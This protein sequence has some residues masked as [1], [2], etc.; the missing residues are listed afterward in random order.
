MDSIFPR[1]L[2][3]GLPSHVLFHNLIDLTSVHP[4]LFCKVQGTAVKSGIEDGKRREGTE[5]RKPPAQPGPPQSILGGPRA[6]E[7]LGH[8]LRMLQQ[9]RGLF[10]LL[11]ELLYPH[12]NTYCQ[13]DHKA[14]VAS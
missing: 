12:A 13:M 4:W 8:V 14:D 10:S 11:Q 6:W 9:L 1:W 2:Q 5:D 7:R 3:Q